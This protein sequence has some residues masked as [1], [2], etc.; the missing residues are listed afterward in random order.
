[1]NKTEVQEIITKKDLAT[2]LT[3]IQDALKVY[4]VRELNDAILIALNEKF[5]FKKEVD[6]VLKSVASNYKIQRNLIMKS[7]KRGEIQE[8]RMVVYAILHYDL[9]IS[10]RQIAKRIFKKYPNSIQDALKKF[11][12]LEPEKFSKDK[13]IMDRYKECR[14]ETVEFIITKKES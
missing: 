10:T 6:F 1:M 8:A 5:D 14:K 4:S 13:G 9:E 7:K 2:L 11:R 12:A 3:N